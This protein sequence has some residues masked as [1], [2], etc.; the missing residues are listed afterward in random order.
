MSVSSG[1][2]LYLNIVNYIYK[3]VNIKSEN[4]TLVDLDH[5]LYPL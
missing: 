2:D 5:M 1:I 4:A 3:I